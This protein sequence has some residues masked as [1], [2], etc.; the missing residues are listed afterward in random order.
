MCRG[1]SHQG[2]L[3]MNT[4]C[5]LGSHDEQVSAQ[6]SKIIFTLGAGLLGTSMILQDDLDPEQLLESALASPS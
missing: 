4:A 5:E 3:A 2:C 1:E 6:L